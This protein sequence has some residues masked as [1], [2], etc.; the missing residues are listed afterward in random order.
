MYVTILATSCIKWLTLAYCVT[1]DGSQWS[2]HASPDGVRR[3]LAVCDVDVL[4]T[5]RV[6]SGEVRQRWSSVCGVA[7]EQDAE[8]GRI[9]RKVYHRVQSTLWVTVS[10]RQLPTDSTTLWTLL[11]RTVFAWPTIGLLQFP[12]SGTVDN[13]RLVHWFTYYCCA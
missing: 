10:G 3:P 8:R 1:A 7:T 4:P 5:Q 6:S 13:L 12:A 2:Q 9:E 11:L